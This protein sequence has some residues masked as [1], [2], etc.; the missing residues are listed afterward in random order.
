MADSTL[1]QDIA[2]PTPD[3]ASV[4]AVFVT[5]AGA[6]RAA[7][8][9]VIHEAFGVTDDIRRIAARFAAAGFPTL[10]PDFLAGLGPKPICIARF[11][12]SIGR[13]G[14]L[15][16]AIGARSPMHTGYVKYA[17]EDAWQR[18]LGFFGR[19]LAAA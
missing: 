13:P 9:L 4:P 11:L 7:G 18:T 17:A 8:V 6:G 1:M 5:P 15:T 16:A 12:R 14:G 3:G 2:V 19:H 10:A